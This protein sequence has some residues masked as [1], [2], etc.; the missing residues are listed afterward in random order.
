[1]KHR[2][3]FHFGYNFDYSTND[4]DRRKPCPPIPEYL[5]E[6]VKR[7]KVMNLVRFT[8]DQITVNIYEP[9]QGIFIVINF[10]LFM[11]FTGITHHDTLINLKVLKSFFSLF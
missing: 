7:M 4:V 6:L 2:S 5:L 11:I 9:G 3:V 8:P 1:M 10:S